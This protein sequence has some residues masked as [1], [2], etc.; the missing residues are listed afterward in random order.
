MEDGCRGTTSS[1]ERSISSEAWEWGWRG[2]RTACP[3]GQE[4]VSRDLGRVSGKRHRRSQ[5]WGFPKALQPIGDSQD[6]ALA[7]WDREAVLL[8]RR[9][10]P[11]AG[12]ELP[13]GQ[14]DPKAG[15]CG[16]PAS[17]LSSP[18]CPKSSWL[19]C[20]PRKCPTLLSWELS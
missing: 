13:S 2:K 18:G 8:C 15:Q 16:V 1:R 17:A 11:P 19:L 9:P 5:S 10:F 20:V 6:A 4:Q 3:L 7:L 14:V 12:S